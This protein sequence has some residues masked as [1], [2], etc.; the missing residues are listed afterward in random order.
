MDFEDLKISTQTIITNTNWVIDIEKLFQTLPITPYMYIPPPR[1]NPRRK[2]TNPSKID[3]NLMKLKSGSIITLKYRGNIRG[4]DI[5]EMKKIYSHRVSKKVKE[6]PRKKPFR[7][8]MMIVMKIEC[9][10]ITLKLP[11]FGRIQ[12]C[13]CKKLDHAKKSVKYMWRHIY[14]LLKE[15]PNIATTIE[16][17]P[18]YTEKK[19]DAVQ[20]L[21]DLEKKNSITKDYNNQIKFKYP[22][23]I[24]FFTVMIN[25][26]FKLGFLLDR[27][28]LNIFINKNTDYK[29][30]LETS[31]NTSAIVKI[32]S[33]TENRPPLIEYKLNSDDIWI[34]TEMSYLDY[35]AELNK[36]KRKKEMED[37]YHSFLMFHSG[38][39]ILS[40]PFID[41]MRTV[42][43]EFIKF[44]VNN[45]Q[46]LEEKLID[47]DVSNIMSKLLL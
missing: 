9:K 37:K 25:K 24:S 35:R 39:I 27:E 45:R 1:K 7:N 34:K 36:S 29:C 14:D 38:S 12:M 15:D 33:N 32:K 10:K 20:I 47:N 23:K 16:K 42:Y 3:H 28:K 18:C 13:G 2:T 5:K 11:C 8:S 31:V 40:S 43:N 46:H 21:H 4:T 41:E 19:I 44:I 26:D 6:T 22:P 17:Y 30:L